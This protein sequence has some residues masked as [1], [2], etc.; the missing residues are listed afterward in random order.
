MA[1]IFDRFLTSAFSNFSSP[2]TWLITDLLEDVYIPLRTSNLLVVVSNSAC[3]FL[4]AAG[5]FFIL[6]I[7]R[8]VEE[9]VASCMSDKSEYL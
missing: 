6:A 3:P 7:T 4:N 2:L 1:A 9:L 8:K 5:T